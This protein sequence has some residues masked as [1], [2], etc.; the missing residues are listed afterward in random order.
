M[1]L[2]AA[3]LTRSSRIFLFFAQLNAVRVTLEDT[4]IIVMNEATFRMTQIIVSLIFMCSFSGSFYFF[5]ACNDNRPKR[6]PYCTYGNM[7]KPTGTF[8]P[9]PDGP[10]Y[11]PDIRREKHLDGAKTWV[12]A[13]AVFQANRSWDAVVARMMYFCVQT[14]FTIGYGDSVAPV[15]KDE[16]KFSLFLMLTGALTYALVIANMTSVLANANVLYCRHMDEINTM[17]QLMDDRDLPDGLKGRVK[18]SFEYMWS[19]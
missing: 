2:K 17:S 12:G 6:A 11:Y 15:S 4:K 3:R 14:L 1:C 8:V 9:D 7:T 5:L 19:K 16:I 10:G 13:D 18:L